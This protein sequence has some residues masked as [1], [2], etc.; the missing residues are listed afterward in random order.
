MKAYATP[1]KNQSGKIS[2]L[3]LKSSHHFLLFSKGKVIHD[4][5]F[6]LTPNIKKVSNKKRNED[7]RYET[8]GRLNINRR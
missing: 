4:P 2:T 1:N 5:I 3:T 6:Y 7:E 8:V